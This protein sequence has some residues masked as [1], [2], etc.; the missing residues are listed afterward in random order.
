MKAVVK[1]LASLILGLPLVAVGLGSSFPARAAVTGT[2]IV[3]IQKSLQ[4]L[5]RK[6]ERLQGRNQVEK[7]QRAYGYYVDKAQWPAIADMFAKDGTY[8]IGGR[9]VFIGPKRVLQYL[10]T[11]GPIGIESRY[12]GM[13]NHQ[14]FQGV[15]NVS[16][17][18][19]HA[20][21]RWTAF[22]MAAAG[23]GG[24]WGDCIYE[25]E[26]VKEDGVWKIKHIRAPFM[27]YTTY[28]EG[29]A[30]FAIP[31]THPGDRHSP[32]PDL[33]PSTV[34]LTYPSFYAPPYHY[35][36]PVTGRPM[37]KSNP[38]AGGTAPMTPAARN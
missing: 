5:G 15:I 17:D 30:N 12:G 29:W 11:L 26:Y 13:Y 4:I 2:Q 18:G 33:P 6:I 34:Y 38:A 7:I 31:N 24:I 32:A 20:W 3:E 21:G 25:N 36:N 23:G 1:R 35:P 27:M 22:V 19:K 14:Q 16:P 10:L 9:G 37:P 8:E 28:K